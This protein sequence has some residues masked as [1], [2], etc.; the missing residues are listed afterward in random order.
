LD[1][2]SIGPV[3][4][5]HHQQEIALVGLPIINQAVANLDGAVSARAGFSVVILA[6]SNAA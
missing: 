2:V 3:E 4:Q 1:K 6:N 5:D